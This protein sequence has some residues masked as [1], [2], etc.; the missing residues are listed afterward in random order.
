MY[1]VGHVG[2]GALMRKGL[3]EVDRV[4]GVAWVGWGMCEFKRHTL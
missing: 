2:G 4:R 1:G 3:Y